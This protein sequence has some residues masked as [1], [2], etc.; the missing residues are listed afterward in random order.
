MAPRITL[1]GGGAIDLDVQEARIRNVGL[2][3]VEGGDTQEDVD[4]S[5]APR[6]YID[7]GDILFYD[8]TATYNTNDYVLFNNRVWFAIQDGVTGVEPS[9]AASQWQE[10]SRETFFLTVAAD[11]GSNIEADTAN[12]TLTFTGGDN[13][14]TTSNPT[15][16]T[17]TIDWSAGLGD[18]TGVDLTTAPTDR[19]ILQ[20]DGST[21]MWRPVTFTGDSY[22]IAR[23]DS[24]ADVTASDDINVL[25]ISGAGPVSTSI[26]SSTDNN[27][28]EISISVAEAQPGGTSGLLTGADK[29]LLDDVRDGGYINSGLN[30]ATSAGTGESINL[31]LRDGT[32]VLDS[33]TLTN[34]LP[35]DDLTNIETGLRDH[36]VTIYSDIPALTADLDAS[37]SYNVYIVTRNFTSASS[38]TPNLSA[39]SRWYIDGEQPAT[40][41]IPPG[42]SVGLQ[43][44]EVHRF[45]LT[46]SQTDI[47]TLVQ[48]NTF[49]ELFV[50]LDDDDTN[51]N[52]LGNKWFVTPGSSVGSLGDLSD[53]DFTT[54]PT[55]GQVLTLDGDGNWTGMSV[56]AIEDHG[57][58]RW[59]NIV[60]Y[61]AG[62]IVSHEI[63]GTRHLFIAIRD[64]NNVPPVAGG[65]ADWMEES[66]SI[67]TLNEIGD[68]NIDTP[69]EGQALTLDIDSDD[70][71]TW[72][73]RGFT[74]RQ[75][76]F[77]TQYHRG[78]LVYTTDD[79]A[80]PTN[81]RDQIYRVNASFTSA[82]SDTGFS[83]FPAN[84]RYLGERDDNPN[85]VTDDDVN[86]S[87]LGE[88]TSIQ[89]GDTV[90]PIRQN[91]KSGTGFPPNEDVTAGDAF[92]LIGSGGLHTDTFTATEGQTQFPATLESSNQT[93]NFDG[94]VVTVN[95]DAVDPGTPGPNLYGIGQIGTDF[96][97]YDI[98][99][100]VGRSAG[101]VI[102]LT[103]PVGSS[104][105]EGLYHRNETN[106]HWIKDDRTYTFADGTDGSFTVTDSNGEVVTVNTGDTGIP[107]GDILPATGHHG[108]TFYSYWW[109][110]YRHFP[111]I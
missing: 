82:D 98:S 12:D 80:Y 45:A 64:N 71:Q 19:Q 103:Y 37:T 94:V 25:D 73:N 13:I 27:A 76:L 74:A 3:T 99:F 42:Q 26:S 67:D 33:Q 5:A 63:S 91:I 105:Q 56:G 11:S 97:R 54:T 58:R 32:T 34:L 49:T 104:G 46:F 55:T 40:V 7:R 70:N 77:E 110:S 111:R 23:A 86:V 84:L 89:V 14:T 75:L 96:N 39:T 21:N 59:N 15:T 90:R 81:H 31:D 53:V 30:L 66:D 4:N 6:S 88:I 10:L 65:N 69:V 22:T 72:V 85:V 47:E 35:L 41:S 68:V 16:D 92:V 51:F 44:N 109:R 100:S 50:A 61:E 36:N 107:F 78:E 60:N 8:A 108:D 28:A 18:I 79:T 102:T 95:G 62:D 2:L 24:G 20:F 43:A 57:G 106:T 1:P 17:L 9:D 48:N 52:F 93:G 101:D 29:T 38:A 83:T 87:T